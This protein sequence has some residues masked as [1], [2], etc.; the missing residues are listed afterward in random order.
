MMLREVVGVG[1]ATATPVDKEFTETDS[2]LDPVKTHVD[3]SGLALLDSLVSNTSGT[4]VVSL[5]RSSRLWMSR[6]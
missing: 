2:V 5:D 6:F 1:V 4:G 3:S